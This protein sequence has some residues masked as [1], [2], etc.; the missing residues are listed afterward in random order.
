MSKDA[1]S[2]TRLLGIHGHESK[3]R[4]VIMNLPPLL[5]CGCQGGGEVDLPSIGV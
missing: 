4:A 5:V 2:L 3:V 1:S